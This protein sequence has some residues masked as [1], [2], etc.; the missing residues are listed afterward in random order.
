M[1]LVNGVE[2]KIERFPNGETCIR[3]FEDAILGSH[4]FEEIVL[5]Y[6]ND[7]DL[8]N[9]MFIKKHIDANYNTDVILKMPY[10]PYS[11]MDRTEGINVFTLKSVAE[12]INGLNFNAVVI[13][14][15]HSDVTP[16][17]VDRCV[18][19]EESVE[20]FKE[21]V[22]RGI[23]DEDCYLVFPDASADKRYS[24]IGHK[25]TLTC[26]KHRDF[27]TGRIKSLDVFGERPEKPFKAVIIDDLCSRGGTFM[28][29]GEKLKEMGATEITLVVTHCEDSIHDG[30]VLSG[31]IIDRVITT[32]SIL[33]N[34]THDKLLVKDVLR[35]RIRL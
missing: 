32:N 4:R 31:D 25:N 6:E 2:V 3:D 17:L 8:M 14:E 15:P 19:I 28:L 22:K 33:K 11:R 9:L 1:I 30:G 12:M 7:Q 21:H 16:A 27:E 29:T 24:K 35:D 26:I 20:L 23:I 18:P 5:A 34:G 13:L 10:M